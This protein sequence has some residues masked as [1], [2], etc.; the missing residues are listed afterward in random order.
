MDMTFEDRLNTVLIIDD[1][2]FQTEWLTDYF[3]ARGFEVVQSEDLQS[4]LN[5]LERVRYRYVIIDLSIPF[6]PA[7]AEPL[8]ALGTEFFRYPGLMAAR[9]ARSTGHNTFQVIVYSVH[10]SDDVQSYAD[11]IVCR[12]ILKGRPRELKLHIESTM[13][14]QPHSW[15]SL[16]KTR[17]KRGPLRPKGPKSS[18]PSRVR[19]TPDPKKPSRRLKPAIIKSKKIRPSYRPRRKRRK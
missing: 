1:E 14:R 6:S 3:Q 18:Y 13:N 8:A 17:T 7:L 15:R 9:K 2:P 16:V 4:A 11:R 5:A 12:Y 10:D 19:T